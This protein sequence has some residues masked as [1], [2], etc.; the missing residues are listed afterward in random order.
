MEIFTTVTFS[1]LRERGLDVVERPKLGEILIAN[2]PEKKINGSRTDGRRT[3]I[4]TQR[5]PEVVERVIR[6]MLAQIAPTGS[7]TLSI[8]DCTNLLLIREFRAVRVRDLDA[9]AEVNDWCRFWQ[10]YFGMEIF[11]DKYYLHPQSMKERCLFLLEDTDNDRH[12]EIHKEYEM[13]QTGWIREQSK[14]IKRKMYDTM[15]G[16]EERRILCSEG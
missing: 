10:Q 14:I 8:G 7:A 2:Y 11:D 6:T 4:C 16:K 9:L 12:W 15:V 13:A 5:T 3:Y 1:T